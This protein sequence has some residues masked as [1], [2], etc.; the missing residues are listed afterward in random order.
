MPIAELLNKMKILILNREI[1]FSR[2]DEELFKELGYDVEYIT[3]NSPLISEKP[4]GHW[5]F[6]RPFEV[7]KKAKESDILFSR[8]ARSYDTIILSKLVKKPCIIVAAG[9]EV[10]ID[11][12]IPKEYMS[13]SHSPLIIKLLTK[14]TLKFADKVISVGDHVKK[15]TVKISKN[16]TNEVVH[17]MV[18]TDALK[19]IKGITK[20]PYI[21]TT[22]LMS[23]NRMR[24]K[25]LMP[26]L[27][28][29]SKIHKKYPEY[30]LIYL[31]DEQEGLESSRPELKKRAKELG[32]LDKTI[33]MDF[34]K[35]QEEYVKF[36]NQCK[37]YVQY[38]WHEGCPNAVREARACGVP[39]IGSNHQGVMESIGD[40]GLIAD[41]ENTDDLAEKIEMLIK[42][43][44]LYNKLSK[45]GI[46][47][48]KTVFSKEIKKQKLKRIVEDLVEK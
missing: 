42:D 13:Y 6:E 11:K 21:V 19:K 10:E 28:A 12:N 47:R 46:E 35:T 44:K 24:T 26:L 45:K 4:L 22:A 30:M 9:G 31:G 3:Y 17:N 29:F 32:V 15:N 40:A 14:L 37:I 20:K 38:S 36:L 16:P 43:K 41:R 7:Y 25:G 48:I 18:D 33:F 8:S 34:F 2:R 5:L 1:I 27:E 39:A 23:K